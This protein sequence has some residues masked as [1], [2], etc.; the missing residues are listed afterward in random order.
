MTNI[1]RKIRKGIRNLPNIVKGFNIY[2]N[3]DKLNLIDYTFCTVNPQAKSFIDLGGVWKVN[4]A[5]T[6]YTLQNFKVDQGYIV[7]T[8]YNLKVNKRLA[9]FPN[10]IKLT[11]DFGNNEI[12]GQINDVDVIF[13]FDV[14]LHQV[15]PH[16]DEIL[17]M[18]ARLS[19][20]I[21]IYNQQ[22]VASDKTIRL[23]DL[24]LE[25]Y[26]VIAP[27]RKDD[28]YEQIYNNMDTIH[29]EYKKPWKDIHNIWQWGITDTDLRQKMNSIGFKEV[30]YENYGKFSSSRFFEDHAFIF[31]KK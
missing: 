6:V 28:L 7:D 23:T 1:S 22:Y 16:W 26:K 12:I 30:F 11:G 29:P 4:A 2:V 25:E 19:K 31:I 9:A 5:Y 13:L 18:Y 27:F 21:V 3:R 17:S 24:P 20:C 10:L 15:N 14:L 8:D